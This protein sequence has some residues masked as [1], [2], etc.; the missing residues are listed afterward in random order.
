MTA[1]KPAEQ[2]PE[3]DRKETSL[4]APGFMLGLDVGAARLDVGAPPLQHCPHP[5]W[6][7]PPLPPARLH[8]RVHSSWTETRMFTANKQ[9]P[10]T[11]WGSSLP[12]ILRGLGN[13]RCQASGELAPRPNKRDEDTLGPNTPGSSKGWGWGGSWQRPTKGGQGMLTPSPQ[14][15]SLI[16]PRG[17]LSG[18]HGTRS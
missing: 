8:P 11:C 3:S 13:P 17:Q 15:L 10:L 9:T 6:H 4:Q 12:F 16:R 14:L 2:D 1:L 5:P 18:S 7:Y